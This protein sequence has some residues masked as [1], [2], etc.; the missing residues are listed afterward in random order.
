MEPP[1]FKTAPFNRYPVS[2]IRIT[3]FTKLYRL[4]ECQ[5][6]HEDK[7]H[8]IIAFVAFLIVDHGHIN[9]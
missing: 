3:G 7:L 8:I 2:A 5:I 4:L 6:T 9:S 1:F